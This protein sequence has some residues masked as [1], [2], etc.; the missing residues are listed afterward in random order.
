VRVVEGSG[1]LR[2]AQEAGARPGIGREI[3]GQELE[4]DRALRADVL[5]AKDDAHPAAPD[6]ADQLVLARQRR[7]VVPEVQA[8]ALGRQAAPHGHPVLVVPRCRGIAWRTS[9]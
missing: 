2:L 6:L 3:P 5:G 4:G 1:G 7:C 9:A 8:C